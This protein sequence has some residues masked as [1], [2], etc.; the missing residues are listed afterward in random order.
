MEKETNSVKLLDT[1]IF[2]EYN[3]PEETVENRICGVRSFS[4]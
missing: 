1:Q 3:I 2:I 4:Y